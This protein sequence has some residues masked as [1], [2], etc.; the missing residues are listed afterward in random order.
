MKYR[1]DNITKKK[2]LTLG[3]LSDNAAYESEN[4]MLLGALKAAEEYDINLVYISHLE[5]SEFSSTMHF[6]DIDQKITKHTSSKYDKLED[7]IQQLDIDGLMFVGWSK[8]YDGTKIK[9][10][11][12]AIQTIPIFSLGRDFEEIP[13]VFM[14]GGDYIKELYSHLTEAHGCENIAFISPWNADSRVDNFKDI[15]KFYNRYDE[16]FII[17]QSDLHG[18]N[19]YNRV[20][21]SLSILL[22][23]RKIELDAIMVMT[24][25]EGKYVLELLQ[26][27][28]V[29]IPQD[30]K[31][32]CYEDHPSIAYSKPSLTTVD[33][34]FQKI[35][36]YG[37]QQLYTLLT[38][39]EIPLITEVET[40]VLYRE[41]CGCVF[42]KIERYR[43][44]KEGLFQIDIEKL[45]KI[46]YSLRKQFPLVTLPYFK[47][48]NLF[49]SD[50]SHDDVTFLIE[51]QNALSTLV[52]AVNE[53]DIVRMIENYR[54]KLM[55]IY[56]SNPTYYTR[57]EKLWFNARYIIKDFLNHSII[58]DYIKSDRD[59]RTL[60]IINQSLLSA[61]SI[62]KIITIL[63]SSLKELSIPTCYL[64]L[65][66]EK[67]NCQKVMFS[68]YNNEQCTIGET[69]LSSIYQSYTKQK[70]TRFSLVF[71][72][73]HL[74]ND[75]T[76]MI[77]M[78]PT[79]F[80]GNLIMPLGVQ[81]SSAVKGSILFEQS[82]SLIKKLAYFADTDTLTGLSNRRFFYDSLE[83]A[84]NQSGAFS[85]FYI[86]IDGFKNVNDSYGHDVGDLLLQ[87]IS[88]RITFLMK[89]H[90]Y[91]L[92]IRSDYQYK[93]S[94]IY[95]IGGDEF[96]LLLNSN[97]RDDLS[98]HA[99]S[100]INYLSNE[101]LISGY[102]VQV[103]CSIG[104]SK[105]PTNSTSHQEL[106][107]Q[108]DIAL[109]SAK[110]ENNT[111]RFFDD[112]DN[113]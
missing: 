18:L 49:L 30:I 40:N 46:E 54:E 67:N 80:Q 109:Y 57:G 85:I 3:F 11:K 32:V 66:D 91:D 25:E 12:Q 15:M 108:A 8:D 47:L 63:D 87:E 110:T 39:G 9:E 77:L 78:E 75:Q 48:S 14:H 13:C 36:Y 42:N 100:L 37:C 24:A 31:V 79:L 5:N 17:N 28:G 55:P 10:F 44:E 16:Q 21:K 99:K 103:S 111:F 105:F 68:Y 19:G 113:E 2:R 73:H 102:K 92:D 82:Q 56:Q 64:L 26:K 70:G 45:D 97:D 112:L 41:S 34:P 52:E 83:F 1:H 107:K 88:R 98:N 69:D 60:S 90:T 62:N 86:D 29:R 20:K 7:A 101:Y 43:G 51:L 72:L 106:L 93:A 33:F 81:I 84:T 58:T 74:G 65:S 94:S 104:I 4:E 50:I 71:M 6:S 61:Y 53:N 95:R 76:A 22:D 59:K 89:D 27:K 38:S 96:I 35:G 23:D